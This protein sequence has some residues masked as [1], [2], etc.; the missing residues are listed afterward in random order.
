MVSGR[1][2][3]SGLPMESTMAH[4]PFDRGCTTARAHDL[5]GCSIEADAA[6]CVPTRGAPLRHA[7][8][9]SRSGLPPMLF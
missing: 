8:A 4:Y 7:V 9:A 1:V 6:A 2:E 3:C 5:T